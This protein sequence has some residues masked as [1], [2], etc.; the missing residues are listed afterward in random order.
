MVPEIVEELVLLKS[1]TF[2]LATERQSQ[3]CLTEYSGPSPISQIS[4]KFCLVDDVI[5]PD[6]IG[7]IMRKPIG[8]SYLA[9]KPDL[10]PY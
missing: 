6:N 4:H 2:V 8:C 5:Q 9:N 1:E 3:I 10:S 7:N